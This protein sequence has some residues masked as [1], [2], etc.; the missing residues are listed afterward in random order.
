MGIIFQIQSQTNSQTEKE[1]LGLMKQWANAY[2]HRDI[3]FLEK[4]MDDTWTFAGG[5]GFRINKKDGIEAFKQD[6]RKYLSITYQKEQVKVY[7]KMVSVVLEEEIRLQEENS[8]TSIIKSLVTDVF[9][10]RKNDWKGIITHKSEI[11]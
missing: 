11:K 3:T 4:I 7:K 1:I 2:I 5:N 8:D 9:I 10:K 6:K